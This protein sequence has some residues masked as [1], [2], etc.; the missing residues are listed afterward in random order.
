MTGASV[1]AAGIT[2]AGR[3]LQQLAVL[4]RLPQLLSPAATSTASGQRQRDCRGMCDGLCLSGVGFS[5]VYEELSFLLQAGEGLT[6]LGIEFDPSR[7]SA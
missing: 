4:D 6:V 5:V 1:S 3:G 7:R 2:A